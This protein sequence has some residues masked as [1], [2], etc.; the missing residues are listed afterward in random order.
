M[1][2]PVLK[3]GHEADAWIWSLFG[4][5]AYTRREVSS[6]YFGYI[7]ILFWLFAQFPQLVEN[8]Y[9]NNAD[10][11]SLLFLF[12]WLSGD[13]ANL[14]GCVLT[15]QMPF[16]F[17]LAVYFVFIDTSLFLQSIYFKRTRL[18]TNREEVVDIDD[19]NPTENS[20]L[21]P[22][23]ATRRDSTGSSTFLA[24]AS[25][26]F[27]LA[28]ALPIQPLSFSTLD[29]V[30]PTYQIGRF[31][32]WVCTILYVSSRLPQIYKNYLRQ[33]CDGLAIVMFGCALLGNLTY[34][35]SILVKSSDPAHL[36]NSL[37]YL[38]G[39]GG[40]VMFDI[41]IFVQYLSYSKKE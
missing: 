32:S 17:W 24:V 6:V 20:P 38:L 27:S 4:E 1:Q 13:L 19:N 9:R 37:P 41:I 12:N 25:S 29:E 21:L 16:Q 28:S 14:I 23:D 18:S 34:S 33:S 8:A 30:D 26:L 2:C 10:S 5:C 35:I 22:E 39:S 3:G 11:I 40:T 36:L 7:S 15:H 31:F